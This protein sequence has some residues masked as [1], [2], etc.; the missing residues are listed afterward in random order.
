M[1]KQFS[2]LSEFLFD[3]PLYAEYECELNLFDDLFRDAL[4]VDGHCFYCKKQATFNR[5][6]PYEGSSDIRRA[7]ELHI[8]IQLTLRCARDEDHD[9]DFF[10]RI[11]NSIIQKIGQYPSLANI[12]NDESRTYQKV[13]KPRD[14]KELHRA[15]GLAAHGVGVGSFV[16]LRRVFERLITSRFEAVKENRGLSPDDFATMR[17]EEKIKLLEPDL[18]E[19]L[20]SNRRVFA[21]LSKGIHELDEVAWYQTLAGEMKAAAP[22]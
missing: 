15:I 9:I 10:F 4:V 2:S 14:N 21:I 3:A 17:M 12:A 18:P 16:Y 19:F 7:K 1:P 11:D 22:V 20:V 6:T 13:L 8:P 5:T